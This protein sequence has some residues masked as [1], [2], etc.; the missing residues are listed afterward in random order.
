[1]DKAIGPTMTAD[2]DFSFFPKD[3][4][5]ESFLPTHLS[6]I[7]SFLIEMPPVNRLLVGFIVDN[8]NRNRQLSDF[9]TAEAREEFEHYLLSLGGVKFGEWYKLPGMDEKQKGIA[10]TLELGGNCYDMPFR[11][12]RKAFSVPGNLQWELM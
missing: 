12:K 8:G 2:I 4:I 1:M 11:F 10:K 3:S 7:E 9:K 6:R 5:D